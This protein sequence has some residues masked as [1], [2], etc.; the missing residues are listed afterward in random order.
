MKEY[1]K[2]F[3]IWYAIVAVLVVVYLVLSV[4]NE[5]GPETYE[6]TNTECLTQERV[7]DMADKLSDEEEEKIKQIETVLKEHPVGE[8]LS[9]DEEGFLQILREIDGICGLFLH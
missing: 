3:W 2:R 1:M 8:S 7:F 6:R 5:K 4:K 9:Y